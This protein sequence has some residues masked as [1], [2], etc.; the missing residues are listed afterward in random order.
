MGW[1]SGGRGGHREPLG[2]TAT[3]SADFSAR[4]E[5][6]N[7][8]CVGGCSDPFWVGPRRGLREEGEERS[9]PDGGP[10]SSAVPYTTL[11]CGLS[12]GQSWCWYV[13]LGYEPLG[14]LV[15]QGC[16]RLLSVLAPC[17]DMGTLG[18]S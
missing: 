11:N 2:R 3:S 6:K 13:S 5:L 18:C 16:P 1:A 15:T 8:V 14:M 7:G 10:Q 17:G 12:R 4:E 9:P